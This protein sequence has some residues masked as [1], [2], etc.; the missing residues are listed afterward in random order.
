MANQSPAITVEVPGAGRGSGPISR[1]GDQT[2]RRRPRWL[3]TGTAGLRLGR[4]PET[5]R[6][7]VEEGVLVGRQL[8][9]RGKHWQVWSESVDNLIRK[10][11][12]WNAPPV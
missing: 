5:V 4:H 2:P 3:S 12:L 6:R 1:G 10:W 9:G 11:D 7:W 8:G